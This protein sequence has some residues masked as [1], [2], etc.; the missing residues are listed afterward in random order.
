MPILKLSANGILTQSSDFGSHEIL[1]Q[2]RSQSGLG[3]L[4]EELT[5]TSL[6]TST[7]NS[8]MMALP[9]GLA[10]NI[11]TIDFMRKV[12]REKA[13]HPKVREFATKILAANQI[14]SHAYKS[15]A[16][17]IG[18]FVKARMRYVR[19]P[20]DAEMLQDPVMLIDKLE[21]QGMASGDCDDMSLLIA[22]LLLSIGGD[23]LFRAV[24]YR[25]KSG[26]YNHI[27]IVTYDLN[28]PG[29]RE[30]IVLDAILKDKPIGSEINHASGDEFEI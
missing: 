20:R 4:S 17:A 16:L 19:D 23:P 10:G 28:Y 1:P 14:P 7:P 13:H 11:A 9:D 29:Q 2:G 18:G 3:S 27:Y 30:R 21:K 12:A 25:E 24:R 22:T 26:N 6:K 8:Q 5:G 15:E